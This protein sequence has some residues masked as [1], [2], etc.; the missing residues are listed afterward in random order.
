MEGC[1]Y[2]TQKAKP[3]LRDGTGCPEQLKGGE[4]PLQAGMTALADAYDA[5]V[6]DRPYKSKRGG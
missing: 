1:S 6:L 2:C 5:L 3:D 4:V